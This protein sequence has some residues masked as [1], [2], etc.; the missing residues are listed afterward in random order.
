M[1]NGDPAETQPLGQ[2]SDGEEA[3][4]GNWT[5]QPQAADGIGTTQ[6]TAA[7]GSWGHATDGSR[8]QLDHAA[9]YAAASARHEPGDAN[10]G[11]AYRGTT[12]TARC[13][14]EVD[15]RQRSEFKLTKYHRFV[16]T[17]QKCRYARSTQMR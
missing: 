1:F 10:D 3:A 6:P 7:D 14:V 5:T 17:S 4:N 13:D 2:S 12:F 15:G 8:W 11:A 16:F 9:D